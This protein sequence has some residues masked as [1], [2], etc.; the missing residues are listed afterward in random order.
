[1]APLTIAQTCVHPVT[2]AVTPLC[3]P[4]TWTGVV[5]EACMTSSPSCHSLPCPQQRAAPWTTAQVKFSA[6][7]MDVTPVSRPVTVTGV[8]LY[9][10]VLSP[11]CPSWLRPQHMAAPLTTAQ[12]WFAPAVRPVMTASVDVPGSTPASPGPTPVFV[13]PPGSTPPAPGSSSGLP[14][15]R[16]GGVVSVGCG[17]LGKVVSSCTAHASSTAL[18]PANANAKPFM[19]LGPIGLHY[20]ESRG[21]GTRGILFCLALGRSRRD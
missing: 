16:A 20:T 21:G 15:V 11:S 14:T 3:R 1:M 5:E 12:V 4:T 6:A 10:V 18:P 19:N 7:E 2:M 8:F 17:E 9:V 13:V